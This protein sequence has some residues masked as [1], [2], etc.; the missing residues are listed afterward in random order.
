MKIFKF[1]F[2]FLL[3][4]LNASNSFALEVKWYGTTCLSFEDE[5]TRII[6]DPFVTRVS[7]LSTVLNKN[8]G[9]NKKRV[10]KYFGPSKKKTIIL[11]THTHFDHVLDLPEVMRLN[12]NAIVYG[13]KD[14]EPILTGHGIKSS[15]LKII[16][17]GSNL[18]VGDFKVNFFEVKHSSLPFNINFARGKS[19]V[20]KES[21]ALDY[22]MESNLSLNIQHPKRNILLHPT[23]VPRSYKG[24]GEIDLLIVGLTS[25]D[26]NKLKTEV[27]EEI[28]AKKVYP[29]HNENFFND[30]DEDLEKMPFYPTLGSFPT[31]RLPKIIK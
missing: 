13:T 4:F 25:R 1:G 8:L 11:I 29:V 30:F 2:L 10:K 14:V 24:L 18:E 20:D 19:M 12:P 7:L 3:A 15:R 22:K 9:S 5:K 6:V 28:K 31:G 17:E 21:G 27:I 26:I 23:A 16:G